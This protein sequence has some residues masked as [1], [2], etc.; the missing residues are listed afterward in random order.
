MT[1]SSNYVSTVQSL[2]FDRNFN[3]ANINTEKQN[4]FLKIVGK[5]VS[6]LENPDFQ[7]RYYKK[8]HNSIFTRKHKS[9]K[10]VKISLNMKIEKNT[11]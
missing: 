4:P 7:F 9:E 8:T 1:R 10:A 5:L 11:L 6:V 3:V 2:R